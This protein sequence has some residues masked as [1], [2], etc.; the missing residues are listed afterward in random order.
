MT[1]NWFFGGSYAENVPKRILNLTNMGGITRENV[2]SHIK[3]CEKLPYS[4]LFAEWIKKFFLKQVFYA[5]SLL[6]G[7]DELFEYE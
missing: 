7:L 2:A 1:K 5:L 4:A 6:F 3:V